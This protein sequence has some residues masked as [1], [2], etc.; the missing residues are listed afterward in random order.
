METNYGRP[1]IAMIELIFAIVIMGIV[2]MSAPML[3][4]TA[5]KTVDVALQQEG[6]NEAVTRV[7][8]VLTHE[9]DE[10]VTANIASSDCAPL[11][12]VA[13]GDPELN[14]TNGRRIGIDVNS[15]A[16]TS[17]CGTNEF[18][19]SVTLGSDGGE[20]AKDDID[21]FAY[22]NLTGI[23]LGTGGINYIEQT[24]VDI[25]TSVYYSS[26][27]AVYNAST[28]TFDFNTTN[29]SFTQ[30]TNIKT[31]SVTL[32]SHSNV[33]ELNKTIVL[34]AFSC[35]TGNSL[36]FEHRTFP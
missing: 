9:W 29:P 25:N 12:H 21:D 19:A 28:V 27:T 20:T 16:R 23:P 24:T 17:R 34:N 8:M 3:I 7:T 18:N 4:S 31:I 30:S 33:E 26:D 1:A 14:I 35:N 13:S 36:D 11:L 10:N 32:T 5:K 2:M 15:S 6:I 22:I